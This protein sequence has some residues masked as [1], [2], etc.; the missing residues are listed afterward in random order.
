ME[1]AKLNNLT[2]ICNI[3]EIEDI[4]KT[5]QPIKSYSSAQD[6]TGLFYYTGYEFQ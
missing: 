2:N 6:G 5:E 1:Y 4:I 3:N